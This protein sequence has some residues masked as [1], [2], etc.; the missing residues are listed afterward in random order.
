MSSQLNP[1]PSFLFGPF[2]YDGASGELR[3]HRNRVRIQGQ[4]LQILAS[5]LARAGDVVSRESLQRELWAG[6]TNGDFEHGLNAAVNKLRQV[7][8]DSAEQP[9][10]IETLP[11]RG[12]RFIAPLQSPSML[13]VVELRPA[14]VEPTA[15]GR[16]WWAWVGGALLLFCPLGLGYWWGQMRTSGVA[17]KPGQFAIQPP[18]GYFLE[19]AGIRQSFALSPDGK[20]LAFTAM[21]SSGVFSAFVRDL[22]SLEVKPVP[23]GKGAYSVYWSP[24]SRWLSFTARGQLRRIALG[25][26]ASQSLGAP[27]PYLGMGI[28]LGKDRQLISSHNFSAILSGTDPQARE[29]PGIYA[30]PQM[31]PDGKHFLSTR[32]DIQSGQHRASVSAVDRLDERRELVQA[33]SRVMYTGSVR[34]NGGYLLFLKAGT[35]LAQ[36]FDPGSLQTTGPPVAIVRRVTSFQHTGAADFSVAD[37]G[38]LAYQTFVNRSQ[39]TWVSRTGEVLSAASPGDLSTKH[40]R[41]SPDGKRIAT[42]IFDVDRGV[43][44]IWIFEGGAGRRL[45]TGRGIRHSPV[46]SP[47]GKKVVF[48]RAF[49]GF[50]KLAWQ[51]VDDGS[52]EE[53]LP[54]S[55]YMQPSSWSPDGR[56]ILYNDDGLPAATNGG[57]SDIFAVDLKRGP[58]LVPLI[59][60]PFH[61]ANGA[62]SPDGR[63]IAFTSNESGRTEIYVQAVE[64]G[65]SLRVVGK[66]HLLSNKG[67]QCLRWRADGRELFYLAFDG[68]VYA[69]PVRL[70][71]AVETGA[72]IALFS[73]STEARAAIHS[74]LGFDVSADGSRF[75]VPTVSAKDGPA[76]VVVQ[77]WERL[78][79][80]AVE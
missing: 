52:P 31:L 11:G 33:D 67:A 24:D 6:A 72:P 14:V 2:E 26:A 30:W 17:W 50:P 29:I 56:F 8:G 64:T 41:L 53:A 79:L 37:R 7:L 58:K 45:T 65:D 36:P 59:K 57:Q 5:L 28:P 32:F 20:R 80:G 1:T 69:V 42:S 51:A 15:S 22:D 47:D 76:I 63:W 60:T 49:G 19:G 10:Y 3:K 68:K 55:A 44:D 43:T 4:P 34:G 54:E 23:D 73:I 16:R 38:L 21:D 62:F 46:W 70:G 61:E 75:L 13:S 74:M 9:R 35:L 40:A 48:F 12:Y 27:M 78:L 39:L 25:G 18:L 66:R 77:D 71:P